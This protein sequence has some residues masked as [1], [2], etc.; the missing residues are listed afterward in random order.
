MNGKLQPCRIAMT[1][2][3]T[4]T[5][6]PFITAPA[7]AQALGPPVCTV[8]KN[9]LTAEFKGYE[10]AGA[11][12]HLVITLAS[13]FEDNDVLHKIWEQIDAL[14]TASCPQERAE[15]LAVTKTKTLGDALR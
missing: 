1:L 11:K 9:M 6:A 14:T 13:E 8:I 15:V 5:F 4:L 12:A 3:A 2:A 10:P 7:A